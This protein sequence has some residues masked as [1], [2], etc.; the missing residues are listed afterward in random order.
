MGVE[1]RQ[2]TPGTNSV[3]I[4]TTLTSS[5]YAEVPPSP[6]NRL[7]L[8]HGAHKTKLKLAIIQSHPIPASMFLREQR[9]YEHD[10]QD[11]RFNIAYAA[12]A[13]T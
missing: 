5:P 1:A 8:P 6:H 4:Q 2:P 9:K 11:Y 7:L 12:V 13:A 3:G 10:Y